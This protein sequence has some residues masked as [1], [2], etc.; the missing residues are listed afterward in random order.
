MSATLF[1]WESVKNDFLLN[2]NHLFKK[3]ENY[4]LEQLQVD[5]Q[6][7]RVLLEYY[8]N[9]DAL[10]IAT[11][12]MI[13]LVV[14]H[15]VMGEL[16]RNYSQVDRAWSLLPPTYAWHFVIHDYLNRSTIHPRLLLAAVIISI[17]GIR[18]TYNFARKG[19]YEWQG[20]DYR[21]VY[22]QEKIGN[23]GMALLNFV[24]IGPMQDTLLLLM[25][26]PL[27]LNTLS[28][29]SQDQYVLGLNRMDILA[30]GLFLTL[31][32]FEVIADDQ[33]F[34]F[35]TRKYA[36]LE[37]VHHDKRQLPKE[38]RRGFLCHSGLWQ[39]SRHPNFF[40]EISMWWSI[41]LF[42]IAAHIQG[43][44]RVDWMNPKLYLNWT[45]MGAVFLTMLF[46]G[47]TWL[48]EYISTEKYPEY[49]IY[50]QSVNRFIPWFPQREK[51]KTA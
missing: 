27:Y 6:N 45:M 22:I 36:L 41:Y 37:F 24:F 8:K 42:S 46:Q 50:Q 49:K 43:Q 2:I 39:Y 40:A 7:P 21:F 9:T 12:V 25:C 33:Q 48:T 38:Y 11:V 14:I 10:V 35:Q 51:M 16:T 30:S 20:R 5:L 31:L 34:M 47:S 13:T 4:S 26:L 28:P 29:L 17:W 23:L 3:L 19:G 32:L 1:S 18:L 15:C 44:E